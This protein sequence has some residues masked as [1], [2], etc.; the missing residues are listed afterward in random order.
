VPVRDGLYIL[1]LVTHINSVD[2]KRCKH[3]DDNATY[4]WH[5]HFGHVGVKR[6]KKLHSDGLL[7]SLDF[8]SFDTCESCLLGKMTRTPFTGIVERASDLLGIV[9]TDVCGPMSV[10]TRNGYCYFVTFTDDL[11]RYEYIY[12][13]KHKSKTFEKFK[14]FQK[15]VKNQLDRKIKH[16]R[17]DRGGEYLSFEFEAHLKECGIVPQRMP[18][19]MPQRS[20]VSERRNRNLLDSV[21]SMMSLSDLLISF[22][23]YALETTAFI[24]N[25]A[26]SKSVETTL[27]DLWHGKKPKLSF[28]RV[29]GCEAY[30]KKLQPDK[31]ETK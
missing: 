9:H 20:G 30:V 23:G 8:D 13:M 26:P 25:R 19:R 12:L 10:A 2:A 5:C 1:D 22:W 14:K 24:L 31:L 11:S 16:L 7:G 18:A 29:W 3:S 27:Y 15:E 4:T 21:R 6:M 28:L 17:S